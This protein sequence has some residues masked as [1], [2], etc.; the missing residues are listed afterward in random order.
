MSSFSITSLLKFFSLEVL[1]SRLIPTSNY[2]KRKA[3]IQ[4]SKKSKWGTLEFKFYLLVFAIVVPL[5]YKAAMDASNETNPNFPKFQRFL[6]K[7]WIFGRKVDNSDAQYRFFR[8]NFLTLS[9]LIL[10]HLGI[11]NSAI[12]LKIDKLT[13]DAIFG[14][15]FLFGAHG[16]NCFKI[17]FHVVLSYLIVRYSPNSY[18]AK[19][20]LW[21]YGLSTLFINDKYRSVKYGDIIGVLSFMDGFKGIIPRWDVFFNFTLLRLLS[22]NLDYLKKK[23]SQDSSSSNDNTQSSSSSSSSG[24]S[25][26]NIPLNETEIDSGSEKQSQLE[27]NSSNFKKNDDSKIFTTNSTV[28]LDER[29]RLDAPLDISE[30]NFSNYFSYVFYTPLFIA[31]PVITFNDYM[32]QTKT[33]LPSINWKRTLIYGLRLLFCILVMEFLLHY[34]YVVAVAK[35]K[36]WKGDTPFQISMIGLFNL[37][38][39]WLKLLI[40]WRLFRLWALLD[41]ID[42]P[43][44]MIRCMDNNYSAMSFWRAWH[45]SYNKWVVRYLYIPLGGSKNRILSTLATFS[46]VAVW[47]DIDLKLLVWGWLIVLFLLPE[48]ILTQVFK[49]YQNEWWFRHVCALGAVINIWMMMLANLYGFCLGK[50]GLVMLLREMFTT[51]DGFVFFITS[52]ICLFVGAQVM[53]ELRESEKRRGIDVK[54]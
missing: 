48:I 54:C 24:T 30:Y 4:S 40:P 53:F 21:T 10:I 8:D 46:F 19:W 18:T 23:D 25:T 7:G 42:P 36:A 6:S 31:G 11:K 28:Y 34:M 35:T 47:H 29:Q 12:F 32:Y 15:V 38:I 14:L 43:E 5:M 44:N 1:D 20:I 49:P 22:F 26:E 9:A 37:N 41:G 51:L 39:I 3:V 45:R 27:E 52:A 17:L 50:D 33:T 13:F 16:F 2:K